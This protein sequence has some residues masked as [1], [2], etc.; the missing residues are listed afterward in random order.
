MPPFSLPALGTTWWVEIFD[1][2][3]PSLHQEIEYA[4]AALLASI[5][6]RFSRF[7]PDSLVS[8]LNH[9]RVLQTS[10][11][12]FQFLINY[13]QQL[14][15]K[16][17]GT[18]NILCGDPLLARGYDSNY[19]F[20][21]SDR[22]TV[23]GNPVT[24]MAYKNGTWH[25]ANGLLDL[26][27]L[28]KGWAIDQ[29]AKLL[30]DYD[31]NAFLVN[32]GGDLYGTSEQ[33]EPITIYLEHPTKNGVYLGTTTIYHQ[34]FAASSTHKRRWVSPTG[35]TTHHIIGNTTDYDSSFVIADSTL[36]ADAFA[37]TALLLRKSD[38]DHLATTEAFAFG[39]Y[40]EATSEFQKTSDF[41]FISL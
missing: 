24:D 17:N 8:R 28:G 33:S 25:L 16:T 31:L 3:T 15:Q 39:L 26:G 29:V 6:E 23:I 2:I 22:P 18:F 35:K 1:H 11:V 19:S 36:T 20:T 30:R 4:A 13:G 41:P 5:E 9:A 14:Y 12:D 21:I 7:R 34:G 37:T 27:G 32:G 38:L 10:D 40:T